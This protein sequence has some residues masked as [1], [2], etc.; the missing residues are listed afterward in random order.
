[1]SDKKKEN[2]MNIISLKFDVKNLFYWIYN[3]CGEF[4]KLFD[5]VKFLDDLMFVMYSLIK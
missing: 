3:G 4:S 2:I 5:I 1:M